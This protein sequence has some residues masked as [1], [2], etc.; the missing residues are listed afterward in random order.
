[1]SHWSRP[2][3]DRS[4]QGRQP[5]AIAPLEFEA[6]MNNPKKR[7]AKERSGSEVLAQGNV[8]LG[9]TRKDFGT[10]PG[11]LEKFLKFKKIS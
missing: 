5:K 4:A 3:L 7:T 11:N 6:I 2:V 8:Q 1:M 10:L 9:V